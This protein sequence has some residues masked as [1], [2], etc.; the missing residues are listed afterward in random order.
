MAE[1]TSP[2]TVKSAP[3]RK[4]RIRDLVNVYSKASCRVWLT[5]DRRTLELVEADSLGK[6]MDVGT[7]PEW[8]TY[9]LEQDGW[10][11]LVDYPYRETARVGWALAHGIA[12][13]QPFLVEVDPP[14]H[15][16][17]WTDC[18]Y[19]Y[20]TDYSS[21]LVRVA[22]LPPEDVARRWEVWLWWA[23]LER[24]SRERADAAREAREAAQHALALADPSAL[25]LTSD[26]YFGP[27]DSIDYMPS[28]LRIYLN[29]AHLQL[30]SSV[31]VSGE[32]DRGDRTKALAMLLER[33]ATVLPNVR[34]DY[35]RAL[36]WHR[37]HIN[38]EEVRRGLE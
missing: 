3:P 38:R 36:P 30:V 31:L 37:P 23:A 24:A 11:N 16:K 13:G 18:G 33:A 15:S 12:P 20:D 35:L 28:G 17:H 26:I 34:P 2:T 27:Q 4:T 5:L 29:S 19:E 1:S 22:P 21:E 8:L 9:E 14:V 6:P 25:Y 10:D 32:D 7:P